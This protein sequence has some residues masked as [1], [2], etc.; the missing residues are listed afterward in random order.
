[1]IPVIPVVPVVPFLPLTITYRGILQPRCASADDASV[2][3]DREFRKLILRGVAN[4]PRPY[5]PKHRKHRRGWPGLSSVTIWAAWAK[6]GRGRGEAMGCPLNLR[7]EYAKGAQDSHPAIPLPVILG[8]AFTK[9]SRHRLS[10][11]VETHEISRINPG[12]EPN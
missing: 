4:P 2:S 11:T 8:C 1:M 9:P 12:M 3:R 10:S 6:S 7:L 5:H